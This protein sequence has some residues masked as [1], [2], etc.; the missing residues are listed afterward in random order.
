MITINSVRGEH[1]IVGLY[2]SMI[3]LTGCTDIGGYYAQ[4]LGIESRSQLRKARADYQA[5]LAGFANAGVLTEEEAKMELY[6]EVLKLNVGTMTEEWA[7]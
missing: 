2:L 1:V 5:A 6:S 4:S 7:A 3:L